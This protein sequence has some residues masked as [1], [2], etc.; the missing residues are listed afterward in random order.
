M[1][2]DS[3]IKKN[4]IIVITINLKVNKYLLDIYHA[5]V[6]GE[7]VGIRKTLHRLQTHFFYLKMKQE[8]VEYIQSCLVCQMVKY[9]PLALSGLLQPLLIPTI[10]WKDLMMD[11]IMQLPTTQGK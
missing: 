8:V 9:Q 11:F 5:S 10:A 3:I 6:I 1:L 7:H 4:G 2:V